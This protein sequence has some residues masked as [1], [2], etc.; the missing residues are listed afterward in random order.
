MQNKASSLVERISAE[1]AILILVVL[2][3]ILVSAS[4]L[5][6]RVLGSPLT[7]EEA[8]EISWNTPLMKEAILRR[9]GNLEDFSLDI[10]N[11][12][13]SYIKVLKDEYD[14]DP[15]KRLPDDHG[16]WKIDWDIG[17]PPGGVL[18]YVDELSGQILY[19]S[20]FWS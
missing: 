20:W 12:N 18:Q 17:S 14:Y 16:I 2:S 1:K 13:A 8:I 5:E 9:R 15:F 7:R 3:F 11:W 19:E 6:P 10:E 4:T